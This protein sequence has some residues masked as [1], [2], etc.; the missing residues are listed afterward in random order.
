MKAETLCQDVGCLSADGNVESWTLCSSTAQGETKCPVTLASKKSLAPITPSVETLISDSL[1][2]A[3]RPL[4]SCSSPAA[5]LRKISKNCRTETSTVTV[6]EHAVSCHNL[7]NSHSCVC[8]VFGSDCTATS[9]ISCGCNRT[10]L[11]QRLNIFCF[12]FSAIEEFSGF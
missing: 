5:A 2:S 4:S 11:S 3:I 12:N 8:C 7:K 10:G 1:A 6:E 9:K